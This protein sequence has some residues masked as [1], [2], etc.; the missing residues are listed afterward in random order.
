[1]SDSNYL[2]PGVYIQE[3]EGPAPITGVSTSIAA[4]I[5]MAER[6]PVN[7]PILCTSP[8]DYTRW[9]GGL[10]VPDEFADPTD[11]KRFHCYLP[12]AVAG[13][14]NNSGQIAYVIRVLPD[15][16][17][18][19]WEFLYDRTGDSPIASAL[20]RSA[21]IGD[22]AGA[23]PSTGALLMLT[24]VPP[25]PASIRIDNGSV[26]EYAT[27]QL[28]GAVTDA[29]ALDLPLSL[30]HA[31]GTPVAPYAR[32]TQG[33]P[34]YKL[35][36]DVGAGQNVITVKS[37]DPLNTYND[38]LIELSTGDVVV[39]AVPQAVVPIAANQYSITLT[40]PLVAEFSVTATAVAALVASPAAAY[41]PAAA[42]YTLTSA[43]T[44]GATTL[45]V[46]STPADDLT[47]FSNWLLELA[48]AGITTVVMV[49]SGVAAGPPG[50]NE[51]TLTLAAP[52]PMPFPTA[53]TVLTRLNSTPT[54]GLDVAAS[55]GDML[56]FA[57]GGDALASGELV[58]IDP[59]NPLTR[60][61]RTVGNASAAGALTQLSFAA[62]S[63][64]AW[65]AKTAV[66]PVALTAGATTTLSA[67]ATAG[68]QTLSL[69]SRS[70]IDAGSVLLLGV[71][72]TQEYAAVLTVPGV[73]ASAGPD[74][75]SVTLGQPLVNGYPNGAPVAASTVSATPPA[76]RR[77]T[78]LV[79]DAPAGS[80]SAIVT[81]SAG[82]TAG[83]IVE[84]E[85]ADGSV[86]YATI[87]A[88]PAPQGLEQVELTT[89]L[90]RTH[91]IG[92]P[93]V[94]RNPLIQ[95]QAL[96][97]GAW[98]QRIALAPQDESPGLVANV[99]VVSSIALTQLKLSALTGIQPGSYLELL[100]PTGTL[101]DPATPL[102][103]AAVNRSATTIT[104]DS[105]ISPA[106]AG[107]IGTSTP[108]TRIVVRSREFRLTVYLYRHPDP[109]V[110]SRNTQV[111]QT[112]TFRNLSMDP[113][114]SQYFQTVIG[115]INGPRRL[116]DGRP[117][118]SSWLI[119]VQDTAMTQSALWA[120][121]LGPEPL[122]D[123][124][125][126]GLT[127]PAQHKLD[128]GGDDSLATVD[129]AMY[130]GADAVDPRDRTGI[131]TIE[132]A[133]D[134]SIAAIPGQ[135][136]PAIQ[137]ALIAF[138]ETS[139]SIFAVL[140]PMYPDSAIADIQAQR[141]G[142]DTKYAAIYYPWLTIPD[143]MPA[144]LALVPD[145]PLPPSGHVVGIYAR[146]DDSRGVFKAPA[147]EVVQGVTGLTR[148]LVQGDQDVL[149]PAPN[150]I[151]VIRD[152]RP[153]GRGIRVWGA[154]VITSDD[155]N[156][157]VP[158]R[159]LLIFIEQSLNVGLQDVVF[160]PNT[161]QLWATVER[162]IENFLYTVFASGA[163]AGA[164]PAQSYFVRCDQ[165]TMTPDD[166]DAGR[167][168]ALVGVAPAMPA[169][170]VIIQIA[171]MTATNSQ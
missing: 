132:N 63:S 27:I 59:G 92:S 105:P 12:Y 154:R 115:A 171:L 81:W 169:E 56:I 67:A 94:A 58:D 122:V 104:L 15:E 77:A 20:V 163:F 62:P 35:L 90:Q 1:M 89:P 111:I 91:P 85:L 95:V 152:F 148:T 125:P 42:P 102:K 72:P 130:I 160:E 9:F 44:A 137:S 29:V 45:A 150:N 164:T 96:D 22:G 118:G 43:A 60:E 82:W 53:G 108:T 139:Q 84:I 138:C 69:A 11:P 120:P 145:F 101:V 147:N 31:Q 49:Q 32:T 110:P 100:Y 168:I 5:G 106:Q 143:P 76:G 112:E 66:V 64:V 14:F 46:T 23:T 71:A 37:S 107:A 166:I 126:N 36:S 33:T 61:V 146:V 99:Q 47:T 26:S 52:L 116:S 17:T 155:N 86:A 128:I 28:S 4:F 65:P 119:R 18:A 83:D 7:F 48:N 25:A 142:F 153:Q 113:R 34:P 141:Q 79:L 170:F 140:D 134:V 10:L 157:Y 123:V 19:A 131:Y 74:P 70:G 80:T 41:S 158:V 73:R 124:L 161:P 40:Q 93:V 167:L 68:S 144:N 13:F 38:L 165:T 16:A 98:G 51:Y 103:V 39:V 30:S 149:N 109:A 78:R 3:L 127:K 6:G 88:A 159:R 21:A 8:G 2:S 135:G 162:L 50:S 156:K 54:Y 129:D 97:A 75:G 151:N 133:M 55:G 117:E 136:T 57:P 24:P 121:R 87:D 114:H